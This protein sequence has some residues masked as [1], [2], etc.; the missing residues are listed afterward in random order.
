MG[1]R[2]GGCVRGGPRQFFEGLAEELE[3]HAEAEFAL[4]RDAGDGRTHREHLEQVERDSGFRPAELD[5][6]D[7][8]EAAEHV[9]RW[10]LELSQARGSTGFGPAPLTYQDIAAWARL[11]GA[12]PSPWEIGVLKRL[13]VLW[14][15]S[16]VPKGTPGKGKPAGGGRR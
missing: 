5:T 14:L 6:P 11:T 13:D 16:S 9:W 15:A 8:P 7:I 1:A 10:F 3:A 2:A 4:L 12:D